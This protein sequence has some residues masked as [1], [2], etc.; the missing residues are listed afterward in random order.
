[1]PGVR[2]CYA[3]AVGRCRRR[4]GKETFAVASGAASEWLL[5]GYCYAAEMKTFAKS[6]G[7]PAAGRRRKDELEKAILA[8]VDRTQRHLVAFGHRAGLGAD[9]GPTRSGRGRLR[10]CR[11][12]RCT[13]RV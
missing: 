8:L 13:K 10:D 4:E 2:H 11:K 12:R 7:I 3:F 6:L 9:V 1:M 5:D